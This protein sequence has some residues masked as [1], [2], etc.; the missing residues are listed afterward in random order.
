MSSLEQIQSDSLWVAKTLF[1]RNLVTGST[2]NLSFKYN[3]KIYLTASGSCFGKL[4]K[5]SFS[6]IDYDGEK[7]EGSPTKEYPMHLMLLNLKPENKVVLH[8][9]SFYTTILSCLIDLDKGISNL[10]KFTPYLK[11]L[12]KGKINI[13]DYAHPGSQAL[14]D[15]FETKLDVSV[16]VYILRNHGVFIAAENMLKAFNILEELEASAKIYHELSKFDLSRYQEIK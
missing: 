10:F 2:G 7:L 4:D 5:S 13:V 9:H 11:M 1:D 6:I 16:N 12:T 14:F 3:N 15:N 8:T